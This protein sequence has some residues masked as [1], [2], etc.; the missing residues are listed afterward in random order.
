VSNDLNEVTFRR[1]SRADYALLCGWLAQPHVA[2]W[3]NHDASLP[4]VE[5]DFGPSIRG[6]DPAEVFIA[7]AGDRPIGL[8]QRYLYADN[9]D[10]QA[11][12]A[13]LLAV[14]GAALG[15]DYFIGEPDALRRGLGTAMIRGAAESIW[16]DHPPAPA[17]IVPV[18][19]ANTASWRVLERA[20]FR[21]VGEGRWAPGNP[22]DGWNHRVYRLD[23]PPGR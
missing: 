15:I 23:R 7:I 13:P 22:V 17:I 6:D 3:W 8:L 10:D 20:G 1:L 11:E 16:K 18:D 4:A 21:C 5:A 2:R 19:T 12:L 14:P 9:P